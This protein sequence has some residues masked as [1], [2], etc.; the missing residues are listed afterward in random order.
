M[1][2]CQST[3]NTLHIRLVFLWSGLSWCHRSM[4]EDV[5]RPQPRRKYESVMD[6]VVKVILVRLS[7]LK[8]VDV[9]RHL[10]CNRNL[11]VLTEPDTWQHSSGDVLRIVGPWKIGR[12]DTTVI[13]WNLHSW[14]VVQ[15]HTS[16]GG[17]TFLWLSHHSV[18]RCTLY[19]C[20]T[21]VRC[22]SLFRQTSLNLTKMRWG[23]KGDEDARHMNLTTCTP[24]V[25]YNDLII[26][27]CTKNG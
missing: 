3:S 22:L 11:T 21:L 15:T 16:G 13:F 4:N 19:A 1:R 10:G 20:V 17:G 9:C 26:S 5:M 25:H 14:C 27:W 6:V 18:W 24:R 2:Y 7:S 12:N 23:G 8:W